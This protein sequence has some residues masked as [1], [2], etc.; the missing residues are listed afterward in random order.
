MDA[1]LEIAKVIK[2][3]QTESMWLHQLEKDRDVIAHLEAVQALAAFNKSE[4]VLN[5]LEASLYDTTF[6]YRVRLE[7]ARSLT[8]VSEFDDD[9]HATSTIIR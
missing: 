9:T 2:Y 6:F 7:A 1:D 3:K 5:R 4:Q 8:H